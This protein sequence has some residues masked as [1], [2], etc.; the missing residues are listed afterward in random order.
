MKNIYLPLTR[1]IIRELKAGD[2]VGLWGTLYT[3][4]DVAHQRL[5]QILKEGKKS[6]FPLKDQVIYYTGPAPAPPG[7]AIGSCG[8]TTSSRMDPFASLLL[9]AGVRGMI[10][11]GDRSTEVIRAIRKYGAVYFV[12]VGGAGAL[13]ASKVEEAKA[14]AFKDLGPEAIYRLKVR[15]FP[16]IV[17]IDSEGRD[18]YGG[19]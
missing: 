8:P 5:T 15:D 14:V 7:K 1:D 3:A 17:G 10:G 4:R 13:S 6:P 16:V 9:A 19:R 2:E 11:K 12:A 18:I